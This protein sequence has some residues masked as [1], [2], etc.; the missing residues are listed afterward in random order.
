MTTTAHEDPCCHK[1]FDK[2]KDRRVARIFGFIFEETRPFIA[3]KICG[4]KRCPKATDCSLEC[5]GSNDP[6]Q[7]GS[8][9]E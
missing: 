7:K 2:R 3:C 5:T 1:C 6:G 4:N 9:Y 8:V